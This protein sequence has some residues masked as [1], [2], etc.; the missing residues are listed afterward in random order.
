MRPG[1]KQGFKGAIAAVLMA[2]GA[3]SAA[4]YDKAQV[5]AYCAAWPDKTRQACL[6]GER[7]AGRQIDGF[8][9]S[10]KS[11][12]QKTLL[13]LCAAES[14]RS[15][16]QQIACIDRT[17]ARAEIE[18]Y[19]QNYVDQTGGGYVVKEA[20]IKAETEARARLQQGQ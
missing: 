5:K 8:R 19:C 11:S 16:A 15:Y 3:V 17:M 12:G 7:A 4:A 1:L 6:E 13:K 10:A 9:A 14:P 2:C 20:C 18:A